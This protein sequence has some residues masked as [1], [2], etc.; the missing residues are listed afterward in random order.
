MS[1]PENK[2]AV[3]IIIGTYKQCEHKVVCFKHTFEKLNNHKH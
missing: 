3:L 1:E 2:T